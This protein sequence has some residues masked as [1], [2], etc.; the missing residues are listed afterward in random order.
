MIILAQVPGGADPSSAIQQVNVELRTTLTYYSDWG[1]AV[2]VAMFG[3]IMCA[4]LLGLIV[5]RL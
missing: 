1:V 2:G 5:K 3:C 4:S